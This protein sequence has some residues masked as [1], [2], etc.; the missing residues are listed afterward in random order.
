[1]QILSREIVMGN[2]ETLMKQSWKNHGK[3][4]LQS[5]WEPWTIDLVLVS[6]PKANDQTV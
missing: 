6:R 3:P 2:R 1:M 4:F 5:L